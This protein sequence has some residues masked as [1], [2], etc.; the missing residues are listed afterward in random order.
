MWKSRVDEVVKEMLRYCKVYTK[1]KKQK[2]Y[3]Q[4]MVKYDSVKKLAKRI[5]WHAKQDNVRL[6]LLTSIL[7]AKRFVA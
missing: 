6:R 4:A 5:I 7:R 2:L 1:L 3:D